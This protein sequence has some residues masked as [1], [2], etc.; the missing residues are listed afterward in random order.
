M[1]L[2]EMQKGDDLELSL[3]DLEAIANMIDGWAGNER[4]G[5]GKPVSP[6][7]AR[8]A[9]MLLLSLAEHAEAQK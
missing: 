3:F 6:E 8:F 4:D 5:N 2:N 9:G 7:D 1:K